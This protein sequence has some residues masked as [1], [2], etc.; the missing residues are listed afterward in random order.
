MGNVIAMVD[1][2]LA[3]LNLPKATDSALPLLVEVITM[4]DV[5]NGP[6]EAMDITDRQALDT[7]INMYQ[8]TGVGAHTDTTRTTTTTTGDG[9]K[10][11]ASA[12]MMHVL[13]TRE[14]STS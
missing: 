8:Q 2:V 5:M 14:T 10:R 13:K 7:L 9:P 6:S 1:S 3:M 12:L 4:A 11:R